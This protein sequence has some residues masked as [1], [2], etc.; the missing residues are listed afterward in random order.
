MDS[1][2]QLTIHITEN[3]LLSALNIDARTHSRT[4]THNRTYIYIYIYMNISIYIAHKLLDIRIQNAC[5]KIYSKHRTLA[6]L[7]FAPSISDSEKLQFIAS[8]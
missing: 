5:A 4:H 2:Q 3:L 1:L 8:H 6:V 7:T